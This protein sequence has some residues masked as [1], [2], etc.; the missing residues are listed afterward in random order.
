MAKASKTDKRVMNTLE[1]IFQ[2]EMSGVVRYLHYS[3][4]VMGNARIPIQ[5]WF[6]DQA[7]E[8]QAHAIAVGEKITSYGGHPPMLSAKIKE[9]NKH[10]TNDIL[11]ESLTFEEEGRELYRELVGI[12]AELEDIALEELAREM[13]RVETEHIDEVLKMLRKG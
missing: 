12:A 2:L 4:M 13:V 1:Q 7:A 5:K 8:S 6:R 11:K 9:T 10:S 3:F